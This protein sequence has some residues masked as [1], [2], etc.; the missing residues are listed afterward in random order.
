LTP[1][2]SFTGGVFVAAGDINGD[3]HA[4]LIVGTDDTGSAPS[5]VRVFDGV[6]QQ[7]LRSFI[8]Y[9]GF[10]GG[11]RVGAGD[12]TGDGLADII[13]GTGSGA[14]HVKV[15]D[16]VDNSEIRSF[17]PYTGFAGGIFVAGETPIPE[18]T[19][20]VS[21]VLIASRLLAGRPNRTKSRCADST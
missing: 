6:T 9:S 1:F 15:F 18:P 13:T 2:P 19:S 17:L 10:T 5:Q 20:M 7:Q 11:V 3:K 4:D 8:P 21:L 16:A 14:A 12:V